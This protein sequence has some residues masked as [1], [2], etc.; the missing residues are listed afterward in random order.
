MANAT[1][2]ANAQALPEAT[3]RRG[4]L[5]SIIAAGASITAS[6]PLA[7][8][9]S[10][11]DAAAENAAVEP[12][13]NR[14]LIDLARRAGELFR[15]R[16]RAVADLLAARNKF[17]ETAPLPPRSRK[18]PDGVNLNLF[19]IVRNPGPLVS[20]KPIE[21]SV[22][23]AHDMW[24]QAADEGR[25]GEPEFTRKEILHVSDRYVWKLLDGA[26]ESGYAAASRR[27]RE[28]DNEIRRLA[29]K[30]FELE[31]KS[32]LGVAAQ[33]STLLVAFDVRDGRAH[34]EF[35][36]QLAASA[37]RMSSGEEARS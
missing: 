34:K 35:A 37:I 21:I 20:G 24:L 7:L 32:S 18:K 15:E 36:Q 19:N 33:A 13:E 6:A 10:P 16:D 22:D 23:R 5:R 27:L 28:L 30:V 3:N 9:Y 25:S 26:H 17:R 14:D 29:G 12:E 8:T 4:F 1:L 2:R 11:S 31:P